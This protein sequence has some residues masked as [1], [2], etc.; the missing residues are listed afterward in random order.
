MDSE[1][2]HEEG[3]DEG[4][5][6]DLT[7]ALGLTVLIVAVAALVA[8]GAAFGDTVSSG[9]FGSLVGI[10]LRDH[11]GRHRPPRSARRAAADT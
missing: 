2:T 7:H 8:S 11:H 3:G 10:S 1:H 4:V 9:V 6:A 5:V